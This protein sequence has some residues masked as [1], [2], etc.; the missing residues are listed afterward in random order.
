MEKFGASN[1]EILLIDAVFDPNGVD[2]VKHG[3]LSISVPEGGFS[4][5]NIRTVHED[6]KY[7]KDHEKN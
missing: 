4:M 7:R 5:K 6:P 3:C 1:Y 2:A